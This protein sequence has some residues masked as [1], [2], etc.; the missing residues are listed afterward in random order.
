MVRLTADE[1]RAVESAAFI[2]DTTVSEFARQALRDRVKKT[3]E[4]P[5]RRKA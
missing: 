3:G 1:R 2:A 4:W 5:R